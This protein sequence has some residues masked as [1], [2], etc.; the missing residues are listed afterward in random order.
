MHIRIQASKKHEEQY[1]TLKNYYS[2][3]VQLVCGCITN[4]VVV[5]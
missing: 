1:E 4:V 3:N 5:V 2:I